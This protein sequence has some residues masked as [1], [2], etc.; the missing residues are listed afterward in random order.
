MVTTVHRWV[1]SSLVFALSGCYSGVE[2]FV[3]GSSGESDDGEAPETG[4]EEGQP[5][6]GEAPMATTAVTTADVPGTTGAVPMDPPDVA[7]VEP[8]VMRHGALRV[9]GTR[10]V[11]ESG[12]AVQLK[13]PS[14]MWLNWETSGFAFDEPG[15]RF[16]RN[17]WK[18]TVIRAAMGVEPDGAY[19]SDP[20]R[21]GGDV[22]RVIDTA[23]DLG[24][25]VIVD[26]HDHTAETHQAD[27]IEFF[28]AIAEEY[29]DLP[30]VIYEVYNEPLE[31]DWG[32][33]LKPYHEALVAAIRSVDPD[34]VIILGTPT[35]SQR[36]DEAA[37]DPVAGDNLMYTLHFYACTHQQSL[38]DTASGAVAAGLPLFVTEWGA[39][40]ADGGTPANPDL[41][42]DEATRWHDWMN[43]NEISWT[44]W[45]LDDCE[46]RTCYFLPGTAPSGVV[47]EANLNGHA[48][49]VR[50]QMR[51]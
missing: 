17:D 7:D 30:N 18:A 36:V 44:A 24:L 11:D 10:L 43:E 38:R 6:S 35:W 21:A 20:N 12:T 3:V 1:F 39:T 8:P 13:G 28:S 42:V 26:W 29:G 45:K 33:T 9:E 22:R 37:A 47:N 34:N 5:M 51:E 48:S 16:L 32:T 14:S 31:V 49:F 41:C 25:Y 23:V 46:D 4:D 15:V 50:E 2:F 40:H 19:L 27:A